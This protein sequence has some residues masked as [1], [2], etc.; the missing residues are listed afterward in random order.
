[1][2]ALSKVPA[3]PD[4]ATVPLVGADGKLRREWAEYFAALDRRERQVA[5]YVEQ[6]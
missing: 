1:M 6:Q 4:P 5:A 3:M 2:P